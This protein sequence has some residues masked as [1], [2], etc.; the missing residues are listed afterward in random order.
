VVTGVLLLEAVT[1]LTA[2]EGTEMFKNPQIDIRVALVATAVLIVSGAL[3]GII[4]ARNA[5][6]VNPVIALR[7]E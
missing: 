6:K 3:A 7:A 4:P 1:L 2:G 5:S